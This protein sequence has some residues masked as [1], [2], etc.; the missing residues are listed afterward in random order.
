MRLGVWSALAFLSAVVAGCYGPR[1]NEQLADPVALKQNQQAIALFRLARPDP[2]CLHLG[3]QIGVREGDLYRPVQTM[4]LTQTQ[5][6]LVVET[7]LPPG[8]YHITAFACLRARSNQVLAEPQGNGLMRHSYASFTLAPGEIVN[9][10]EFRL[11]ERKR[12]HGVW[13]AFHDVEVVVQD[14]PLEELQR[15]KSQRPKLF[16]EMRTRLMVPDRTDTGPDATAQNCA[17]LRQL[18]A[19]GKVQSLPSACSTAALPAQGSPRKPGD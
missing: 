5:V 18:Q 9:L 7:I 10:G 4:K 12:V 19:A 17:A 11:V 3:V 14:W 16:A 1:I 8:T 2:S 13:S 15:F 6:T